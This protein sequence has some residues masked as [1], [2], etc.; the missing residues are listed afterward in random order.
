LNGQ[1]R[2]V[3]VRDHSIEADVEQVEQADPDDPAHVAAALTGVV[4]ITVEPGESVGAGAKIGSIEAM[5]MESD[6]RPRT[7]AP[8]AASSRP[9]ARPSS[10]VT[11]CWCSTRTDRGRW[12]S[13]VRAGAR[14]GQIQP[15]SQPTDTKA[16]HK[17][18]ANSSLI[19]NARMTVLS[20]RSGSRT[21]R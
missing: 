15:A 6:I 19:Q 17:V 8:C 14:C 11:C 20:R 9:A 7:R 5:K 13:V 21:D 10:W 18:S 4:T 16:I 2:P 3:D 12:P 1:S